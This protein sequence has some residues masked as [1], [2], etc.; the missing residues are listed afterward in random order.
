MNRGKN[1]KST[2]DAVKRFLSVLFFCVT[3]L[4][5][6][7]VY[8]VLLISDDN[9]NIKLNISVAVPTGGDNHDFEFP[10]LGWG[11]GGGACTGV[12]LSTQYSHHGTNSLAM[13]FDLTCANNEAY[14]KW[15]LSNSTN[16]YNKEITAWFYC[17]PGSGGPGSAPNG[18]IMY[19]Q[20]GTNWD[21]Y[22]RD[23]ENLD[24]HEGSWFQLTW[25]LTNNWAS[26]VR[27]VGI[28]YATA[29]ACSPANHYNGPIY[30]DEFYWTNTPSVPPEKD[31]HGFEGL[32]YDWVYETSGMTAITNIEKSDEMAYSGNYSLKM[33]TDLNCSWPENSGV[34]KLT[35]AGSENMYNKELSAYVYL[36]G[37]SGGPKDHPNG[38]TLYMKT[39]PSWTWREIP[40]HNIGLLTNGWYH[41]TISM[42]SNW[43][44][45]VREIGFRYSAPGT[46][47]GDNYYS[48][49]IYLDDV[50]WTNRALYRWTKR[51]PGQSQV[52]NKMTAVDNDNNLYVVGYFWGSYDFADDWGGGDTIVSSNNSID[53]CITKINADGS[54][55]WTKRLGGEGEDKGYGVVT[56]SSGN[57]YVTGSF[58][59]NVNFAEDWSDLDPKTSAGQEDM[60]V[61]KINA[62][63]TYGWTYCIGGPKIDYGSSITIDNDDIFV[64][65]NYASSNIN[66]AEP[67]GGSDP[68]TNAGGSDGFVLKINSA[69]TYGGAKRFGGIGSDQATSI[70]SDK[71]GCI[72][73]TGFFVNTVDFTKDWLGEPSDIKTSS[74]S[75]NVFVL[76]MNSNGTYGWTK[77]LGAMGS[78]DINTDNDRNI[79][80]TGSFYNTVDFAE[81]W[82]Y[83]DPKISHGGF[84]SFITKI[85]F[86][87]DYDWTRC[88]GDIYTD[89]AI[90]TTVDNNGNIYFTGI[91]AG[92]VNF[93]QDWGSTY[94]KHWPPYSGS[95]DY[96]IFI[97]KINP[98]STFGWAKSLGSNLYDIANS[99]IADHDGNIYCTGNANNL[100]NYGF[101]W[102]LN[103]TKPSLGGVQRFL[104]KLT[105]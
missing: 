18:L 100:I 32:A 4:C 79:I 17:P 66:F 96:D 102:G 95:G 90:S 56:D 73:V 49:P 3:I 78:F 67:W 11:N 15:L 98:D 94:M 25:A 64:S 41:L 87:G 43:A 22:Q 38:M 23:W 42:I 68:K 103:D 81:D 12:S 1:E 24:T 8:K 2:G 105:P 88:F 5:F 28:K 21:W 99:I 61:T 101:D 54:Y 57:I 55:A 14:V 7:L 74:A 77:R 13:N 52:L 76:K 19:A 72:Y 47:D 48:G 30:M 34:V 85:K 82:G 69:N 75:R 51:I 6:T 70:T 89:Q 31:N 29:S 58:E 35:F 92:V 91:Y 26:N 86:D 40:W 10:P 65:G 36:P 93:A 104:I 45:D 84:D 44:S 16:L 33:N 71:N 59:S 83:M 63:G 97:V 9:V 53:V 60:F 46:C 80:V 50:T 27:C 20:V 39:G 37:G 62:N